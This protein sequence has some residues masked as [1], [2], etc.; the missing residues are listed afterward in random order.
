M[1]YFNVFSLTHEGARATLDALAAGAVD[2]MPKQ[3]DQIAGDD[4]AK[5]AT[6][7]QE[8][9]QGARQAARWHIRCA[10]VYSTS[11]TRHQPAENFNLHNPPL[12]ASGKRYKM[13]L[14]GTSTGGPA[15]LQKVLTE[16]PEDFPYPILLIQHMPAAFTPAFAQRLDTLCNITVH[17]AEAGQKVE[18]GHAYLAPGGKQMLLEKVA[19]DYVSMSTKQNLI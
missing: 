8:K 17:H 14:I 16:L 3:F 18:A 15:A 7:L 1:P 9:D 4:S 6:I 19:A 13:V 2:Y 5:V 12:K 11:G 10:C